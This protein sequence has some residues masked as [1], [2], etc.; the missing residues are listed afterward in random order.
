[1]LAHKAVA[2]R[3]QPLANT[4]P[5]LHARKQVRG[6]KRLIQT[7]IGARGAERLAIDRGRSRAHHDEGQV[8]VTHLLAHPRAEGPVGGRRGRDVEDHEIDAPGAQARL[9]LRDLGHH[10]HGVACRGEG[11]PEV[12]RRRWIGS[13][14]QNSR[15]GGR[16]VFLLWSMVAWNAVFPRT[17]AGW[18]R[19]A[20]DVRWYV[21]RILLQLRQV[22]SASP[23]IG[24]PSSRDIGHVAYSWLTDS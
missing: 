21:R 7:L 14:D 12:A 23:I 8:E 10:F 19:G 13:D 20:G 1:M 5:D 24:R 17:A 6:G 11:R 22:L 3:A 9:S 4:H 15:L 18:G 2:G 16:H